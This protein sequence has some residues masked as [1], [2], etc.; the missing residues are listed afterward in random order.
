[1]GF[2]KLESS[3]GMFQ[4]FGIEWDKWFLTGDLMGIDPLKGGFYH[5][6]RFYQLYNPVKMV[7]NHGGILPIQWDN[8]AGNI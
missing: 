4:A 1:M 3:L 7:N 5:P 8:I 6:S 2:L